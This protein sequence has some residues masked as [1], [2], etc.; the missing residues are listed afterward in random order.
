VT[1]RSGARFMRVA[2]EYARALARGTR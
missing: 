1:G 2:A